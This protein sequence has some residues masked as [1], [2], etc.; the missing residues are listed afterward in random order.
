MMTT[1]IINLANDTKTK[2]RIFTALGGLSCVSSSDLRRRLGG[3]RATEDSGGL[4]SVGLCEC[5]VLG[6][7]PPDLR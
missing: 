6:E 2:V 7:M 3:H 1:I 4:S 5:G